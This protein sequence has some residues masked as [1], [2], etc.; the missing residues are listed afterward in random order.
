[1]REA[2]FAEWNACLALPPAFKDKWRCFKL[3]LASLISVHT[4]VGRNQYY[5]ILG[6]NEWRFYTEEQAAKDASKAYFNKW[7]RMTS[8]QFP[9]MRADPIR[10]LLLN[11]FS[12]LSASRKARE[13]A[14]ARSA[15]CQ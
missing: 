12:V 6:K 8:K 13:G 2:S 1:M 5:T 14:L 15:T 4:P 10:T 3:S 11:R 7:A 9:K